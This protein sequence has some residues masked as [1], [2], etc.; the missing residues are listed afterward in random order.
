MGHFGSKTSG[1]T[2]DSDCENVLPTYYLPTYL[3]GHVMQA[4]IMGA[5][6]QL[7]PRGP[8]IVSYLMCC[9]HKNHLET[10]KRS[11]AVA[12]DGNAPH[13]FAPVV[14]QNPRP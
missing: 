5:N 2:D 4:R 10:G 3:L 9:H 8:N 12:A 13:P 11:L 7:E 6:T 1:T 14:A